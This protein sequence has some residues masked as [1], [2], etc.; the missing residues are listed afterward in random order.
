MKGAIEAPE[1][2]KAPDANFGV[3]TGF[4]EGAVTFTLPLGVDSRARA[5]SHT[6]Q[7]E[8]TFQACN[9]QICLLPVTLKLDVPVEISR[10]P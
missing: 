7:V 3:E 10:V 1:P 2:L 5:A 9:D 4:Y 6:L 8:V